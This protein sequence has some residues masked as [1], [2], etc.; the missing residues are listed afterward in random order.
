MLDAEETRT[1]LAAIADDGWQKAAAKRIKKL[2]RSHRS[3]AE[4]F[5]TEPSRHQPEALRN[6]SETK[7]REAGVAL[8]G[9]SV[10]EREAVCSALHPKLGPAL[11]AWWAAGRAQPY[12]VSWSRR[13]YRAPNSPSVTRKVRTERLHQAV[14]AVGPYDRDAAW[15]AAW[16]PALDPARY[17][18]PFS[19]WVIGPL[20][21]AAIDRGGPEGDA[22]F[23]TLLQIADGEHPTAVMGRHV[24]VALLRAHRADGWDFVE[25]LLL[26]AQRQEG[27]R[28]SI[29]EVADEGA[30]EAFERMLVV[31]LGHDLLRFAAAVRAATV[32][33]G[34]PADVTEIPLV[35]ERVRRLL[36]LL[37]DRRAADEAIASS[38]PWNTYLGL[39]VVA[40]DD[41]MVA[42]DRA[43]AP[44]THADPHVR[45]AGVRFLRNTSLTRVNGRCFELLE[46]PDLG[47]A[48]LAFGDLAY[49]GG[50]RWSR[51]DSASI[52][53]DAF[54]RLERLAERLP[55]KAR[56]VTGL[57][58]EMGPVELDR[59]DVVSL[60][61]GFRGD[62]PL[63]RVAAW[64]RSMGPSARQQLA[65]SIQEERN[66]G[67]ELRGIVIALVGDRS[68]HVRECA[69]KA[70]SNLTVRPDEA[71]ALEDL[72]S[73][74]AGDLRRGVIAL[75]LRQP[76]DAA[77]QSVARLWG[78]GNEPKR[79]AA[80]EMLGPIAAAAPG[81]A[82][83]VA[84][85][86]AADGPN[87]FQLERLAAVP[88]SGVT[89]SAPAAPTPEAGAA[90]GGDADG[91]RPA[92]DV[93]PGLGLYDPDQRT[94]V[95]APGK[96]RFPPSRSAGAIVSALDDL[97]AEHR[98]TTFV[99]TTWQGAQDVLLGDAGH[100]LPHPFQPRN[101]GSGGMVLPEVFRP[102]WDDRP[103]ALRGPAGSCDA[104]DALALLDGT[105]Q[106][107]STYEERG[108]GAWW[109]PT[110][111]EVQGGE[112]G[113]LRHLQVV[114][115]VLLWLAV[116]EAA[117]DAAAV[118]VRCVDGVEAVL[119]RIPSSRFD[120]LMHSEDDWRARSGE[121]RSLV[122]GL[123][124]SA[125]LQWLLSS[126]THPL[127][128]ESF[129]RWF[130]LVQWLDRPKPK[131]SRH[132]VPMPLVLHGFEQGIANDHDLLDALLVPYAHSFAQWTRRR[133]GPFEAEHPAAVEVV[134]RLRDRI[135][136]IERARGELPT[137]A[138]G[139]AVHVGSIEGAELALDLLARLG[140]S[141]LV[142]GYTGQNVGRDV[143][144]SHLI[145]VSYSAADD[146]P[147]V[148]RVRARQHRIKDARL[149]D[150]AVFAPQWARLVEATLGWEGLA[151]A[152][153]WYHAHTKD[154][155]WTVD[156]EVRETW[157]AL[158]AERT[159][160]AAEDLVAGAVDVD[161]Y[162]RA[163]STLGEDRWKVVH[164][165]AK[166]A[167]GGSGH[168]RAQ[169]YAEAMDGSVPEEAV[170]ERIRSKRHQDSVRALG[171]VPLSGDAAAREAA[172]LDRYQVLREFER[173]SRAF[174]SQR[175]ASEGTAVRIGVENLARTAGY[176]DPQRFVWAM[177][178]AEAGDLAD[179]PVTVTADD[180]AV[181]LSVDAEGTPAI[182]AARGGKKLASVPAKHRKDPAIVEL[183]ARK[184]ALTRQARRVRASL[185]AA[186]VRGDAFVDDDFAALERHP[187][188]APM[189]DL[190]VFVDED[191]Q[192]V[193]RTEGSFR[194]PSG[195][196]ARTSGRLR[197]AHPVD[198]VGS[199]WVRWQEQVYV[200]ERKQ[201]F[202]QVFRELYLLTQA[203]R[204]TGPMSRRWSGHQIQPSQSAALFGRRGW[205]VDREAG[206]V[207]LVFH[208]HDTVA[209]VGFL[210]G[211]GTPADVEL[212][213]IDAV[214]F[215][216]RGD[217]LAQ[218]IDQVPP[219]VF[220][221]AMRD[222]DLVVSVAHAGGVDPEATASTVEMR[223]ALVRE[224]ARMLKLDNVREVDSHVVIEGKLGEYSLH[225][226][227]GSVHRR[228]GGA[229]C[230]IP[231][232]AQRRGRIFLPFADDD[233]KTAEIV[234]KVLLLARDH[235]IKDPTI[236]EQ[237]RS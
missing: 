187:V 133:R 79:D 134:D 99:L 151:D 189:L 226:G 1:R 163:R 96:V 91:P 188:V 192:T 11:A 178:A 222:L 219:L 102:W 229:V 46:D 20:L 60:L 33:L 137:H 129:R 32:W 4:A 17:A 228:P 28:Q 116:D 19:A 125:M 44:L 180:L 208:A 148:L 76:A 37:Q 30:P 124:W 183:T 22:V 128:D 108:A 75:L 53:P 105:R 62:R 115:H 48:M 93:G 80:C 119:G 214:Y 89:P 157:A 224:A 156:A 122:A 230:I 203:E 103:A 146:D 72:L 5:L 161:W 23:D 45:A 131:V 36:E 171:L 73:R 87:A 118:A 225:L 92:I 120:L 205:L 199:D 237:L 215:T 216:K 58:V 166:L 50:G 162:F 68:A 21:A 9:L 211:F 64:L 144:F 152:V 70:V 86:L 110:L 198:L 59:A 170:H 135:I 13:A 197:I 209:R 25:R 29:L 213:T 167:S 176:P 232:D 200:A 196:A 98:D 160:L 67:P 55:D 34:F 40:M 121:W 51:A 101:T 172:T 207:S 106:D 8:D 169:L 212:P 81:L 168:R 3:I 26:A 191:G 201:P 18:S 47:V 77:L 159:P 84:D 74:K 6:E 136:A 27:L 94:P 217:Y 181:T 140:R 24:I 38:D 15:L 202:R 69:V 195:D 193:R 63:T 111:R 43:E 130:G 82:A 52:P 100:W 39:N 127:A 139:Y 57:G 49:L 109:P 185:E 227:S 65:R 16:G 236:L 85:S 56:S 42:I 154:D 175:Q 174:G 54:E 123:A 173:G 233:P 165:A 153:W 164:K 7:R 142:R 126:T 14:L 220:S 2:P 114:R 145:Q 186:M 190:L 182:T 71:P 90:D 41:V 223:A 143:V 104:L 184:T 210:Q 221:E 138:S 61:F 12:L 179:G 113:E 107:R 141:T 66:P 117:D 97:V 132:R 112:P 10:E 206:D 155:R 78:S 235:T 231:V 31:I 147:E 95:R 194:G 234:A 35:K 158:S 150:L 218:P 88:G 83:P 204:D 149:V 177:E